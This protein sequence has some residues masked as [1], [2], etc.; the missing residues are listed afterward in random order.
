MSIRKG[1][2]YRVEGPFL[3]LAGLVVFHVA[4]GG[5]VELGLA[6]IV[7][8]PAQGKA[9]LAVALLKILLPQ[10]MVY[11]Q[12]VQRQPAGAGTV[13]FCAGRGG[14]KVCA[15]QPVQKPLR[16]LPLYFLPE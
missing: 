16:A 10:H 12:A 14:E 13:K 9:L 8:Q 1:I 3:P 7:E 5:S 2:L 11:V 6:H 4:G 15:H